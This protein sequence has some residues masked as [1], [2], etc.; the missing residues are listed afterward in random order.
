MQDGRD[1]CSLAF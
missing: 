1:D